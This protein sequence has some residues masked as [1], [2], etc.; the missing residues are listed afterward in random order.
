MCVCVSVDDRERERERESFRK[1]E[2]THTHHTEGGRVL[3][4]NNIF[5]VN[6]QCI[7]LFI[8]S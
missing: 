2:Q 3:D 6:A 1:L 7:L 5:R 4:L 8:L